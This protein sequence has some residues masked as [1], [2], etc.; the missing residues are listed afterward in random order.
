MRIRIALAMA[1]AGMALGVA[2]AL[3]QAQLTVANNC[4]TPTINSPHAAVPNQPCWVGGIYNNDYANSGGMADLGYMGAPAQMS[5]GH[6]FTGVTDFTIGNTAG[7]PDGTVSGIRVDIPAG[8]VSDPEATPKCS[9]AQLT[10]GTCPSNTQLGIVK[11]ESALAGLDLYAGASVYNMPV[12]SSHCANYISDY[13]FY[14][15]IAGRVD[16]CGSV[17][18]EP[19]YNLYFTIKPPSTGETVSSTL[20]FW[21]VPGDSGH[22]PDRGWK[23]GPQAG[24]VCT[25]PATSPGTP[26]GTAF[27]TNPTACLPAGQQTYLTLTSSTGETVDAPPSKTPVPAIDC[28]SLAFSPHLKVQLKDSNQTKVGKHPELVATLGQPSGQANISSTKLTLPLSLAL[29]PNNSQHVCS[30]T[31]AYNDTC[32]SRTLIG[33]AIATTPVLS[34]PISG[35]VYLVQGVRCSSGVPPTLQGTCTSGTQI[36]T[37][38]ALLVELRGENAAIDLHAQSSVSHKHLVTTFE[39]TPDD[40]ETSFTLTINGGKR[41][42]I[43]VTGHRNLCS[44]TTQKAPMLA[45]GYNGKTEARTLKLLTP[46]KAPKKHKKHHKH[47]H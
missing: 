28:S 6:P 20:I 26:S 3:A 4:T 47:H 29:D 14:I 24:L 9:D 23:C 17:N 21:G 46:C 16:I 22:N 27:I 38:P 12:E 1:V 32:P 2:P 31:D 13:A 36:R 33:H 41:G 45:T 10:A 7:V 43:V 44:Y 30:V 39:N 40:P 19:P 34:G 42:I 35:P 37:L 5:G 11:A 18:R 15:P 25:P 8:L